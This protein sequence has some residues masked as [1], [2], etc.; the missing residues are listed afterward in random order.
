MES[1]VPTDAELTR[2]AQSGDVT[3]LGLLL[4]RHQ[5]DM[6]AVALCV[7]GHGPDA[8]DAVQE[9]ALVALR[10]IGDVRDPAAVGAWLRMVVRNECRMRLRAGR[11]LS[12]VP[13]FTL[14]AS[15]PT[16][17]QVLDGHALRDWVWHAIGELSAP[18][19]QAVLLRHF[20]DVTTY[21]Q[22][23]AACELPV[24]TVRSRLS[25]ART[26]LADAL[27]TTA[28]LTHPDAATLT[29]ASRQEAV[30]TLG[31]AE[32]G[33]FGEVLAERWTPTAEIVGGQGERGGADL[34]LRGMDGDLEVGVR[35]RVVNAIA[36]RDVVIWEMDLINPADQPEHCPPGVVWLMSLRGGRYDRLRLFHPRPVG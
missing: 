6:R 14:A 36:S 2:A 24:G 4:A 13:D 1:G 3:S 33:A 32:R 23:A 10:R 35:Q 31:A 21:E 22:I 25:Q 7:V 19:R 29:R 34:M 27:L 8:E 11:A 26:K 28:D 12:L 5:A 15:G 18:L 17:D 20:S 9:A 30:E 16:P